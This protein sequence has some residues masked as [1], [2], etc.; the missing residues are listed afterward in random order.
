MDK[1]TKG[2][3]TILAPI[4][5]VMVSCAAPGR[6]PN[7]VTL[8]WVGTVC[9]DPPLVSISIRPERYSY[10]LIKETEEFVINVPSVELLRATDFCGMVSGREV[11]KF[12]AADL[13]PA[14]GNMVKAPLIKEAPL[15]IE[16]RVKQIIPL[17]SHDLFI[18]EVLIAHISQDFLNE[19]GRLDLGKIPGVVY[20]DGYYYK[21]RDFLANHGYSRQ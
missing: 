21:V 1:V 15:N 18:A 7:I 12:A 2:A 8:A 6:R 16:C 20:G 14:E 17:G 10:E 3:S 13:T 19:K 4:P 11:D 5:V 9:S